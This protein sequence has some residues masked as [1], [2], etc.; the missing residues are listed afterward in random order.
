MPECPECDICDR[1][2]FEVVVSDILDNIEQLIVSALETK[3]L[4]E[5]GHRVANR[6][7]GDALDELDELRYVLIGEDSGS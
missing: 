5:H 6:H 2:I 3:P 1:C 4:R 7:L